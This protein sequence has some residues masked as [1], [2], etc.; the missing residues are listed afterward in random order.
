MKT[1]NQKCRA[2][3]ESKQRFDAS[4]IFA[5]WEREARQYVVYSYGYHFPMFAFIGGKWY[6][7]SDKYSRSTTRHQSQARLYDVDYVSVTTDELKTIL[8]AI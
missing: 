6:R 3:V 4:N 5:R 1:S 8:A 2:F 7:N